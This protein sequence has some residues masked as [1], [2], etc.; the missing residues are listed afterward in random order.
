MTRISLGHESER[1]KDSQH[2]IRPLL[3]RFRGRG[4]YP[5][6]LHGTNTVV[7]ADPTEVFLALTRPIQSRVD[8]KVSLIVYDI[9][10]RVIYGRIVVPLHDTQK[11]GWKKSTI[12][13][14][15]QPIC[16]D[17]STSTQPNLSS[18]LL[19]VM[20]SSILCTNVYKSEERQ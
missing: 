1:E 3:P 18:S 15:D 11:S 10:V 20:V 5:S 14:V 4:T 12:H 6:G 16:N 7:S 8:I 2:V 19:T 17:S 9:S 13:D